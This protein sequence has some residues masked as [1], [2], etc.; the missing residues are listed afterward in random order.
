[1]KKKLIIP[2]VFV[3]LRFDFP[4]RM[5]NILR[6]RLQ[7]TMYCATV[8]EETKGNKNKKKRKKNSTCQQ[9]SSV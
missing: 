1:M 9:K 8:I 5:S 3:F 2:S 6:I 4:Y 7:T